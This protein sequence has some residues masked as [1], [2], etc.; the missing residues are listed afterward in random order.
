MVENYS[1]R[2]DI[3]SVIL[4]QNEE[5]KNNIKNLRG[6]LDERMDKIFDGEQKAYAPSTCL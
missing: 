6:N 2:Q 5:A 1:L 4:Q 3:K